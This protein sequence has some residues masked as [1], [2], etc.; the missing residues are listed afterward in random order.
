MASSSNKRTRIQGINRGIILEAA[1]EVFST[2]GF[3]GSTIDQIADKAGM[4]KPNLLYYFPRKE[5]IYV[6]VLENTLEDWLTPFRDI[7]PNGDPVE[8]L[9]KYI[10]LKMKLSA[11]KPESSRLFANEIL[12]GAP[13]IQDFLKT[14]LK[15]LVDEKAGVI[16]Q[17]IDEGR[18]APVDPHHLIFMIWATTQHYAD[19]DVQIRAILPEQTIRPGFFDDASDAILTILLNGIKPR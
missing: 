14:N 10:V 5:D 16:R 4:S 19:F 17:W 15:R 13:A 6:T 1:L 12:H 11:S 9:R 2:Y 8:E 3:R 7:D 18:L